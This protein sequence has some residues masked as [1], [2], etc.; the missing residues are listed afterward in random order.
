MNLFTRFLRF[1]RNYTMTLL[2]ALLLVFIST[3][4]SLPMPHLGGILIDQVAGFEK[5]Q[6]VVQEAAEGTSADAGSEQL[7]TPDMLQARQNEA[8]RYV[9]F[10]C[11][12]M[13]G[14]HVA[15]SFIGY[16][17]AMMLMFVGNRVVYDVRRRVFRHLQRLSLRYFDANPHGRIMARVLYDVEAIQGVM[18]QN[19]VD[20]V[21]NFVT[22]VV[23][24]FLLFFFNWRLAFFAVGIMPLYV[25][26][27]MAFKNKIRR[28]ASEARDQYAEVY[29]TLSESVSGVKIVKSF[30]RESSEVRKFTTECRQSIQLNMN[31]GRWR[32]LLGIA[33][34]SVTVLANVAVLFFGGREVLLENR[35]TMGELIAF[36]TYLTMLYAPILALVTIND[37]INTAMTAVERIFETLDTVPDVTERSDAKRIGRVEGRVEFEKIG[38]SYEAGDQ[39]L[40]DINFIAE[41]GTATALVGPSGSGKTTAVHLIPRFY[42]PTEGRILLD[43]MDLRDISLRSLRNNIGMVLQESFLFMGTLRENIKYGRPDASDD[44]VIQAAIAANCHDFIMEFPDGYETLVGERGTRLSG[45]QRQRIAIARAL[46]RNPRILILD[47]ATSALDS[48][49]E[50][51]IQEA[52]DKLMKNRT[53]FSIAHR[54]STVMNANTI[55]VLEQGRIVEQ[56]THAELA[57]AGGLYAKLCEVQ[58]KRGQ[59]AID[60]FE[61]SKRE[62]AAGDEGGKRRGRRHRSPEE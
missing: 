54:L 24:M 51:L 15:G 36:R 23:I 45:G 57:N 1:A 49:S 20:L 46:L 44:D 12:V 16:S 61:A 29:S 5:L 37:T 3:A 39:V 59:E 32:T 7:I 9:I 58:F 31:T 62:G 11:L 19:L 56:G 35:M 53:S 22:V 28:A 13:V 6:E 34:N 38:F 17:R 52:L 43:G 50:A 33:A 10:I 14:L 30:A 27:F 42:D 47:E 4:M 55:L 25:I 26:I 18:S 60:Q 2:V 41:P 48:E 40:T 8:W 21:T